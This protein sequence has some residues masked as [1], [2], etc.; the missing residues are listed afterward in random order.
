VLKSVLSCAKEWSLIPTNPIDGVNEAQKVIAALYKEPAVWRLYFLGA[1]L[2]GFRRGELL[3][4]EWTD[5]NFED[6]SFFIHKSIPLTQNGEAIVKKPKTDESEGIVD[7]PE[8]YM[9][10]LKAYYKEWQKER[11]SKAAEWQGGDKQYVFHSGLG[12]PYDY[13]T[14]TGTWQKSLNVTD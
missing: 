9:R 10:E 5:V 13:T 7:M 11:W 6:N 8:W 1:M 4:L 14:P 12:K 2:G 3:A